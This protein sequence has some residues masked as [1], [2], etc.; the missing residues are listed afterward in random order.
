MGQGYRQAGSG[1]FGGG[2]TNPYAQVPGSQ[3]MSQGRREQISTGQQQSL[4]SMQQ[5]LPYLS[6]AGYSPE[7]IQQFMRKMMVGGY[8]HEGYKGP[9]E[10]GNILYWMNAGA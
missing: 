8:G 6:A 9:R 10:G 2:P 3:G 1:G 5:Y 7:Q 4:Q